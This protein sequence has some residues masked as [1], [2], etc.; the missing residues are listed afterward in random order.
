LNRETVSSDSF[1]VGPQS[2]V[3]STAS[4]EVR[5]RTET[6]TH[7]IVGQISKDVSFNTL[8]RSI[9]LSRALKVGSVVFGLLLIFTVATF[10]FNSIGGNSGGNGSQ[11]TASIGSFLRSLFGGLTS[12][13][14]QIAV[15]T[16]SNP[17]I[18]D[19]TSTP[20]GVAVVGSSGSSAQDEATKKKIADSFS[21]NVEVTADK[22]GT[23]GVI[24]PVFKQTN[25]QDFIYVLVPVNKKSP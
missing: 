18:S 7:T 24:K 14:P 16:N 6:P 4:F 21:D 5:P 23:A 22:S 13:N 12:K 11:N 17:E 1:E 9:I 15:N 3:S 25:G 8:T 10:D 20:L 19:A 2:D